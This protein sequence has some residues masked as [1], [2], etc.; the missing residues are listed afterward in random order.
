VTWK[1]IDAVEAATAVADALS[2]GKTLELI[3]GGSR[4]ALG[5]PVEADVTLD[6]SALSGV[7]TYQPE[8]LILAAE[9]G[10]PMAEIEAL[11]AARGQQLAFEPPDFGPLWGLPAGLGTLGGAIMTGRGGPRRLSVGGPRDHCLGV[12][13]V[14]GFGETFAA[15]GRVVKN[16]TGFDLPKLI[17]GSFGTLCVATELTVK[18]LPAASDT[19]TLVLLGLS[20]EAAMSVMSQALGSPAQ[21]SA[22]AHLPA[23]VAGISSVAGITDQAAATL[24]RLEG[25]RPSVAARVGHLAQALE[26]AGP[27]ILLGREP[28]LA[29]WKEVAD[30]AFFAKG[31][32]TVVWKLSVAPTLGAALGNRLTDELSGRCYYDWGGG[33]VWLE[34]ADADDAH[35]AYVRRALQEVAGGDGHAT[36]MRAPFAVR[37]T[38]EPFQP[39]GA[40]VAA[41]TERV[42]AQFDPQGIFNPGRMYGG[43]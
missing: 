41:L 36:L 3:G 7:V 35:A 9:P 42:R 30:A 22:A 18:V 34:L 26:A 10:T 23:D 11:L 2:E 31:A 20:D 12:K 24:L 32:E 5:R 8:E 14:N 40:A 13:G 39:L 4:R 1:P 27:Q 37:A 6:L 28:S 21:V 15:G 43:L 25:V 29:I 17:T 38:E 16:V 19:A 33:A